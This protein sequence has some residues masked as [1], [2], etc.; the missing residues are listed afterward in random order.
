MARQL[1]DES[2]RHS[3]RGLNPWHETG[4]I[5]RDR[6]PP[7]ERRLAQLLWRR[8]LGEGLHRYQM[9][10]GPRRVGKTT[11]LRQ[12]VRRLIGAGVEPRRIW[13]LQMDNPD[14][15]RHGLGGVMEHVLAVGGAAAASPAYVMIDE[16]A[17]AEEWGLWLK[18]F[19]DGSWP[20]EILATSSSM[21]RLRGARME[22]GI[23]RWD[24]QCLLPCS[25]SE[26]LELCPPPEAPIP[27][28]RVATSDRF[29]ETLDALAPAAYA[30]RHLDEARNILMLIG[31]WPDLL[32]Q[33]RAELDATADAWATAG[34]ESSPAPRT[35]PPEPRSRVD[36]FADNVRR[37]QDRLRSDV[38]DRVIFRDIQESATVE[39]PA[40]LRDLLHILADQ[41]TGVVSP[42]KISG[43]LGV[44]QPTVRRYSELLENSYL[45]F[46]L[47]NYSKN[48]PAVR[49]RGRKVY[50]WDTAVRNALLSRGTTPLA[51]STEYGQLLENLAASTLRALGETTS[52]RV[53]YWRRGDHE[54]DLVLDDPNEPLAFEVASS[55]RHARA[56]LRAL[57][58]S[59]REFAGRCYLVAPDAE[60]VPPEYGTGGIGSIP[61]NAFLLAVGAQIQL[62]A[63]NHVGL[64]RHHP[65]A[66][67]GSETARH[68]R[69]GA[70]DGQSP[71]RPASRMRGMGSE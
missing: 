33:A 64:P 48:E 2:F 4:E 46:T 32:L 19:Y 17:R 5:G 55:S 21:E 65:A 41:I 15:R 54:V 26:F 66:R 52:T 49:R 50:F 30:S 68:A 59:H 44:S 45:T 35:M 24:E 22:S 56:G 1:D 36:A 20:V 51:R 43:N 40:R 13:W 58:E 6:V 67:A 60:L 38:V 9:I 12:T 37:A 23:G 28:G 25:F 61:F 3:L 42:E 18:A 14:V 62:A 34:P 16:V 7:V 70:A 11:I 8:L 69:L 27:V 47:P 71:V 29:S 39:S 57:T 53:C 10:Q 63:E 31:G